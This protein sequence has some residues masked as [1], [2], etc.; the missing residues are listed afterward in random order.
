VGDNRKVSF[1]DEVLGVPPAV[2]DELRALRASALDGALGLAEWREAHA[3]RLGPAVDPEAVAAALAGVDAELAAA[4]EDFDRF[5]AL[6]AQQVDLRLLREPDPLREL[7]EMEE[8]LPTLVA[9]VPRPLLDQRLASLRTMAGGGGP[10]RYEA[11]TRMVKALQVGTLEATYE[12]LRRAIEQSPGASA[13]DLL[14]RAAIE[15]AEAKLELD[16]YDE[17]RAQGR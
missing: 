8:A 13:Q 9:E 15:A 1:S 10:E 12:W 14:T 4:G 7:R 16:R 17:L 3:E 6:S 5:M 11:S 2:L